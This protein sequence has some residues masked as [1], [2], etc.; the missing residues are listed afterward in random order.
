[1]ASLPLTHPALTTPWG[2]PSAPILVLQHQAKDADPSKKPLY[3]AFLSRHGLYHEFAP[4]EV[5]YR[6]NIAALRKLG[7]RCIVAFSAVG[8]LREE[9]KPRDFLV[10]HQAIDRT[11]GVRPFTYFE[12]GMVGH[13]AFADPFDEKL[14]QVI[15]EAMKSNVLEGEDVK[16][17]ESGTLVCMEGPQFSTRAESN[18]YRSWGA[19]VINMSCLPEA[20][21]A[22]EAEIGYAMICMSTDYDCWHDSN[23]HVTVDM[24]MGHMQANALNA[25]NAV[26]AVLDRLVDV[27]HTGVVA[28]QQW[29]GQSKFAAGMTKAL[30]RSPA[31]LKKLEWLLPGYFHES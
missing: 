14:R 8:S 18:L 25:R 29:N 22:R 3:V 12:G 19:T 15:I 20:K 21:L 1:M 16:L 17:H 6:A 5:N 4:H 30:G 2:S 13:V 24:V 31:T 9:F 26:G 11:K 10:P 23:E 27:Q 28:G 7:V